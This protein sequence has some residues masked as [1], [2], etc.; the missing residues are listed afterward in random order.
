M[1][2]LD[3]LYEFIANEED[4]R[5]CTDIPDAACREVPGNFFRIL[6]G[7]WLTKIADAL[8]SS[9]II[10][11]SLLAALGAP[12]FFTGLLVPLRESGSLLPQLL[13]GGWVRHYPVRKWFFCAGSIAQGISALGLVA[14]ALTLSGFAAGLGV[15]L[16]VLVLSL[17]RGLSSVASK[18]VLGKTIPKSRRGLLNGYS[19][20]AAGLVTIASGGLML[21]A[22]EQNRLHGFS[23]GAL[24]LLVA[25]GCW[26]GSALVF[27]RIEETEGATDGGGNAW[28][29]AVDSLGLLGSDPNFRLFVIVRSLMISSGL[30]APYLVL[31]ANRGE[32]SAAITLGLLVIVS[33]AAALVGGPFWGRFADI[34]SRRVMQLGALLTALVCGLAAACAQTGNLPL[35]PMLVLYFALAVTHQGV[36]LGRKTYILD[37]A[38]GNKRTDYVSVSNSLIGVILLLV[39]TLSALLAQLNL[40]LVLLLLAAGSALAALLANRLEDA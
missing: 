4:A 6:L 1:K 29:T 16:M 37:I 12:A 40:S 17:A 19:A 11:P 14:V 2:Q 3:R 31:L 7:Q 9:R 34:S 10:L 28:K 21:L 5:V 32:H 18:D 8:A 27:S 23:V 26:L 24:C 30:A 35:W 15:T 39:G 22:P 20:S 25:A 33:G 36:R 38:G 13:I